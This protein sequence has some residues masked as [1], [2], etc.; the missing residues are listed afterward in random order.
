MKT[1][2]TIAVTVLLGSHVITTSAAAQVTAQSDSRVEARG[3]AGRGSTPEASRPSAGSLD[4]QAVIRATADAGLPE[5]PVRR[6]VAEG[7]AKGATQADVVRAALRT[8]G[9][10]ALARETLESDGTR[11]PSQGEITLGAEA[12]ARGATRAD[13]ERIADAAPDGRSL[14]ASL[15]TMLS[16]GGAGLSSREVSS[17]IASQL[18]AGAS[19]VAIASLGGLNVSGAASGSL[20]GVVGGASAAGSVTG[21]ASSAIGGAPAAGIVQAGAGLTGSLRVIVP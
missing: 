5:A 15:Q 16:L 6:T 7:E 14:E 10:L 21:S 12:L 4:A 11:E 20:G 19:D 3:Q 13:L 9:R 8:Q 2:A 17:R 18:A 1:I